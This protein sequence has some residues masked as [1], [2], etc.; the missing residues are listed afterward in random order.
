MFRNDHQPTPCVCGAPHYP[1]RASG[2]ACGPV[3]DIDA[4]KLGTVRAIR[5]DEHG[6]ARPDLKLVRG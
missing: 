1:H 2:D 4:E 6:V 3:T 5:F